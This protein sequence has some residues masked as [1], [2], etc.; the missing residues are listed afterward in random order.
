M[1]EAKELFFDATFKVAPQKYY[2][3]LNIW[4]YLASHKIYL[5]LIHIIMTS[6]TEC[7]YK[8]FLIL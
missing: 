8:Y 1:A 4:G 3:L 5:P 6:K 2:Q 7:A